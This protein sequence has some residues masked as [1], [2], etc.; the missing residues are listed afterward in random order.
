LSLAIVFAGLFLWKSCAP[1]QQTT[2]V[3]RDTLWIA[4]KDPVHNVTPSDPPKPVI[5]HNHYQNQ[6]PP[7]TDTAAIRLILKEFFTEKVY[8][9][10][11]R[12]DSIDIFLHEKSF[13]N[14]LTRQ[15]VGYRWKAP[16]R[17]IKE[18]VT[19][20]VH[21]NDFYIGASVTLMQK[22]YPLLSIGGLIETKQWA[23]GGGYDFISR[24]PVIAVYHKIKLKK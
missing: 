16:E 3:K 19:N 9:D 15:F 14:V 10:T 12:R 22:N 2:T 8:M 21:K 17:L 6:A 23:F 13:K 5:I 11:I 7:Q 18:T 20:T 4:S 24:A 1:E